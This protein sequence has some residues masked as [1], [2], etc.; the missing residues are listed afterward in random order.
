MKNTHFI[1]VL[2]FWRA[3]E[4]FS[5]PDLPSVVQ[6]S[7]KEEITLEP[8]ESFPWEQEEYFYPE[9]GKQWRH[10]LY[11]YPVEKELV[12]KQLEKLVPNP[13]KDYREPLAGKTCLAAIIITQQGQAIERAYVRSSFL[14]GMKILKEKRDPEELP[15]LLKKAYSEY[16]KRFVVHERTENITEETET[17]EDSITEGVATPMVTSVSWKELEMELSDLR[18]LVAGQLPLT[19]SIHCI[20]EEVFEKANQE[21]PFMNSFYFNDLNALI[22]H[23]KEFSPPLKEYLSLEEDL[24]DRV[25]LLNPRDLLSHISPGLYSP[26]RWPSPPEYGLY[27]AQLAALNIAMAHLQQQSGLWGIN[28]PPGTGKTTLLREIV[29]DTIVRRAK[30]LMNIDPLDL[31]ATSAKEIAQYCEYYTYDTNVFGNDGILVA[32]NNN[33]AVENISKELPS[34]NGIDAEMFGDTDYFADVAKN[35]FQDKSCWGMISAVLGNS[36]N[37]NYFTSKFWFDQNG[38]SALLGKNKYSQKAHAQRFEEVAEELKS[39][40]AEYEQFQQVALEHYDMLSKWFEKGN[41]NS[42]LP[43]KWEKLVAQLTGGDYQIPDSS[44]PGPDFLKRPLS[45]L[46]KMTPYS[47]SYINELRSRIFLKSLELHKYAILA[48]AKCFKS[49][50]SAFVDMLAGRNAEKMDGKVRETLW[51]SFF[52]CIPLV[53]TT[54]ASIERL[55][56]NMDKGS[57]GWLLLDEAGQASPASASGALWRAKR[58]ILIGDTLQIPPVVTIPEGLADLLKNQYGLTDN[59]WSPLRSSAQSLADRITPIGSIIEIADTEVWTGIPLRAHRRC[60]EPMFSI[61]NKIAYNNQMVKLTNDVDTGVRLPRSCWIDVK[62]DVTV[63]KHVVMDEFRALQELLAG[64]KNAGYRDD[65]FIISPFKAIGEYCKDML[66]F[67]IKRKQGTIHTF[68]GKE[69]E[70]VL[71]ILGTDSE[72]AGARK[73]VSSTP[74]MLNVAVTRAKRRLYVIG[75]KELWGGCRYFDVLADS[76]PSLQYKRGVLIH[77]F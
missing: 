25:E 71:L 55:F 39:L 52:F 10:T 20:S 30:R 46:H 66:P 16:A 4:T 56:V 43:K 37:R 50:L 15:E 1:N 58:C 53:S 76:V 70:V 68:Q 14:Y 31:F 12:I 74:N 7:R 48:N 32:S 63:N 47:S 73:W 26:G 59:C 40:L 19:T 60:Q 38:F 49:N 67:D 21:A 8:G 18:E 45:E 17:D 51:G 27:S 29:A 36:T 77:Q 3:I 72:G 57:V 65:V 2:K 5:L 22:K 6:G 34:L 64:L 9:K 42:A 44:L 33:G 75:D 54:L 41:V 61:S 28:G 23:S 35:V 24:K 11:F 69:A 13:S 62:G